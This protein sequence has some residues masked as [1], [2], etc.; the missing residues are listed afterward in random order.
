MRP[1]SNVSRDATP[2]RLVW[3][4]RVALLL[5]PLVG[6]WGAHGVVAADP[7]DDSFGVDVVVN[8]SLPSETAAAQKAYAEK[9]SE[10][11]KSFFEGWV[12]SG[13]V[14]VTVGGSPPPDSKK[15]Y[16]F[17]VSHTLTLKLSN[18]KPYRFK[19]TVVEGSSS[20]GKGQ[21]E[22]WEA[23]ATLRRSESCK[24]TDRR[25]GKTT[26][27]Q[28]ADETPFEGSDKRIL[29]GKGVVSGGKVSP[30]GARRSALNRVLDAMAKGKPGAGAWPDP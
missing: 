8:L 13:N 28:A 11:C 25:G 16:L 12:G 27:W 5:F 6:L 26:S 20:L 9:F 7:K 29:A 14:N 3:A 22:G 17:T 24:F 30:E 21:E 1:T 4:V 19:G 10:S 2:G 23:T 15:R 18:V